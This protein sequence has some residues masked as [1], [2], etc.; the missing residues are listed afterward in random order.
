MPHYLLQVAYGTE[1]WSSLMRSPQD[2]S[3]S[4]RPAIEQLGGKLESFYFTFG[5]YDLIAI[6]E[7]PDNTSAAGFAIA[8]AAGGAVK[9][10]RTTPLM[11]AS[12]PV[13]CTPAAA[14][15]VAVPCPTWSAAER[16]GSGLGSM[17]T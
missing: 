4:V 13:F 17:A 6:V 8:A 10:I 5:E 15:A 1:G 3:E 16:S 2:R 7:M 14:I 9:A 11:T 12:G